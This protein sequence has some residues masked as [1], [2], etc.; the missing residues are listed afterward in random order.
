MQEN[1]MNFL[2]AALDCD[3]VSEVEFVAVGSSLRLLLW[4][5]KKKVSQHRRSEYDCM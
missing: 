1:D 3:A 5:A 4:D 2:A